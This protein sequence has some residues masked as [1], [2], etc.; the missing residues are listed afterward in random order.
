MKKIM[1][2]AG[3]MALMHFSQSQTLKTPTPSPT[4]EVKQ[5]FGL[6]VVE[7]SY[8]RPSMKGRGNWKLVPTVRF[9]TGA[10]SATDCSDDVCSVT[11]RCPQQ[12]SRQSWRKRMDCPLT[13]APDVTSPAYKSELMLRA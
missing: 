5:D 9:G 3:L 1:L 10:N 2:S 11:P 7:L 6:S 4:Q 12:A 8:S 13:K